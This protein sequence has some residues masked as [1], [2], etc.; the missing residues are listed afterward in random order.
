MVSISRDGIISLTRGDSFSVP[1][2]INNGSQLKPERRILDDKDEIFLGIMEPNQIFEC[3]LIKKKFR[4]EN[5]NKKGDVVIKLSPEDTVNIIPG[6]Y[7][8]QIKAKLY[9]SDTD[10]FDVNTIVDK[11]EFFITE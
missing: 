6:K 7:Y 1:L 5:T 10:S 11:K 2:F 3:A 8:Y 4:K 9:R